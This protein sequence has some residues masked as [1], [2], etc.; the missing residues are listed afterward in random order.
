VREDAKVRR[1]RE[2]AYERK[3]MRL[4]PE[5]EVIET[6]LRP[7]GISAVSEPSFVN[8]LNIDRYRVTIE[9]IQE[10]IEVLQTRLKKL[11]RTTQRNHHH[12]DSFKE[13]A[14]ALGLDW[15]KDFPYDEQG[16]E[17]KERT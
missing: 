9:R 4:D 11:W 10:P 12:R 5:A 17:Y 15:A 2:A 8:S 7:W 1:A 14:I 16:C 6:F 13:N 3:L